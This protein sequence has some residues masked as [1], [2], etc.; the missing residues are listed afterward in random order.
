MN[1]ITVY[2]KPTC[3]T[4]RKVAKTFSEQGIEFEKVNYYLE[5][6]SKSLLSTL[7]KKMGMKP[8]ELLRK[9]DE[10]YKKLKSKIDQLSED[11]IL[12]LMLENSD[13]IQRPIVEMGNKAILARPL[14]R[15]KELF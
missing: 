11:E 1:K 3:T 2:E 6:F 12:D 5:P 10:A 13:L 8:S 9:N 4:C 7:I 15:I 14:E